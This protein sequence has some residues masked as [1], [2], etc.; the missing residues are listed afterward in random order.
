MLQQRFAPAGGL[1]INRVLKVTG[2]GESNVDDQLRDIIRSS[3]NPIIGLQ[4]SPGEIK[5]RL[6]ARAGSTE[7]AGRLLDQGEA[8]IMAQVGP[9][10]FG[11]DD[12][13]LAGN[14]ARLVKA[15]GYRLAV[16]DGLTRGRV[17][18]DLCP[19]LPEPLFRGGWILADPQS[20]RDLADKALAELG[21]DLALAV[22]G[23]PGEEGRIRT[24]IQVRTRDGRGAERILD[25]G[26][27]P[28]IVGSRALTMTLFTLW[29]F[30]RDEQTAKTAGAPEAL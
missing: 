21:A 11:R 7:E 26:G 1:M 24:E 3:T 6:T 5:V 12:E 30:L 20:A 13:T 28:R 9:L 22:A 18:A 4:A 17:A 16:M 25:L 19:L 10:V 14:A 8:R 27:P 2:I 15:S 29:S 23:F